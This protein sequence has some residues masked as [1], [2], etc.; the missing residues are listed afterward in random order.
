[1][2]IEVGGTRHNRNRFIYGALFLN[3]VP[4]LVRELVSE[5]LV[6]AADWHCVNCLS[7]KVYDIPGAGIDRHQASRIVYSNPSR[8]LHEEVHGVA[9]LAG[10]AD[11]HLVISW[12]RVLRDL[13]VAKNLRGRSG[14]DVL[15][16]YP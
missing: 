9:S 4:I 11:G 3:G 1:M 5:I 2:R 10:D 7:A 14:L 8:D 15:H 13:K 16:G 12:A 6:G